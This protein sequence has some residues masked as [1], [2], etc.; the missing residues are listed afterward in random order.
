LFGTLMRPSGE[1]TLNQAASTILGAI[2]VFGLAVFVPALAAGLVSGAPQLGAGA[3]IATT[4]ALGGSTIAGGML[5][6]GA[7]R[8]L[9]S[10]SAAMLKA[11]TSIT[12]RVS[13]AYEVGGIRGLARTGITAPLSRAL[14][15]ATGPLREAYAQ[16]AA[17][18]YRDAER[19]PSDG[20]PGRGAGATGGDGSG[21]NA[22]SWAR[23]LA[24]R[25]RAMQAGLIAAQAIREGDRPT[26]GAGPDLKDRS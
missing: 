25:Q 18:G 10:T 15:S 17:Q 4:A 3:A 19:P 7:V 9:G 21:P 20:D 6:T 14:H 16:G 22:P 23:E 8:L 5:T 2:A 12:G 24:R 11:A 26:G 1:I 13:T